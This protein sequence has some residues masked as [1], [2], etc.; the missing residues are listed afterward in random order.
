MQSMKWSIMPTYRRIKKTPHNL[1]SITNT[2]SSAKLRT[3]LCRASYSWSTTWSLAKKY[4][5]LWKASIRQLCAFCWSSW[6]TIH[7][8]SVISTLAL[9]TV[10]QSMPFSSRIWSWQLSRDLYHH[11]IHFLKTLKSILCRTF[12]TLK[13]CR[14]LSLISR[15]TES[16]MT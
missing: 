13:F 12:G 14:I 6:R 5:L 10:C 8:F 15:I 9:W 16:Q 11:L 3:Y 4:L 7:S 1:S 2:W